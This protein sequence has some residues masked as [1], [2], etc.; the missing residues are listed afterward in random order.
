MGC[1]ISVVCAQTTAVYDRE[2]AF[3]PNPGHRAHSPSQPPPSRKA[4]PRTSNS[5]NS[6]VKPR[7]PPLRTIISGSS[8][9]GSPGP[10]F[11][12]GRT[13]QFPSRCSR[14]IVIRVRLR[15]PI[16]CCSQEPV[17]QVK[18]RASLIRIFVV[19]PFEHGW[20][21]AE[22][23]GRILGRVRIPFALL[24]L[25]LKLAVMRTTCYNLVNLL[26]FRTIN[27]FARGIL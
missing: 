7:A 6:A 24:R 15:K 14:S 13:P 19:E 18:W 23:G 11:L 22:V 21:V 27:F 17:I 2:C 10:S 12:P 9:S 1:G 20:G 16:L 4:R 25:I 26:F 5:L 8:L 3:N